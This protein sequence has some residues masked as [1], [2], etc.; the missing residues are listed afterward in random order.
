MRRLCESGFNCNLLLLH[1][2]ANNEVG[3]Y[4]DNEISV[5]LSV[6]AEADLRLRG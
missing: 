2:S 3:T 1:F 4:A 6:V 5:S